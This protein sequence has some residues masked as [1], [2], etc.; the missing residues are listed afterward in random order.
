MLPKVSVHPQ[1]GQAVMGAG[2]S[3]AAELSRGSGWG[4]PNQ[5]TAVHL[6]FSVTAK[7]MTDFLFF[8]QIQRPHSLSL[9]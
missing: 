1:H 3:Q 9:P 6:L 8:L 2:P 7:N 5:I 4:F